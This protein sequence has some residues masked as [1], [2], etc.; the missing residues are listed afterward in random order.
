M[1]HAAGHAWAAQ[2]DN[3]RARVANLD[4]ERQRL[5]ARPSGEE[6]PVSEEEQAD[7]AEVEAA[8]WK[9]MAWFFQ[10]GLQVAALRRTRAVRLNGG[11][12]P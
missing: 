1:R 3:V 10:H 8:K 5:L 4:A 6:A 2:V 9:A 12:G 11:A 7:L